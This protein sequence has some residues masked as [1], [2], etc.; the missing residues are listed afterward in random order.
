MKQSLT[1]AIIV[2]LLLFCILTLLYQISIATERGQEYPIDLSLKGRVTK[3]VVHK[4][5]RILELYDDKN[6]LLKSY[7][8]IAL[9]KNPQGHKEF[10]GDS[11][12]PEGL[13]YI[14]S[15]NP[16]SRYFLNLGISYPNKLDIANAKKHNKNAGGDIKIHGLPN[17]MNIAKELFKQYGDWTDGCIALDNASMKELYE[18]IS[19]NTP[20][21]ILP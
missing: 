15:K 1:K 18:V 12:T 9:G 16:K 10:E 6:K 13:Y 5:K 2:I 8:H 3:I 7:P 4:Q 20:I 21:Y 17:G 14:D 11:K 19:I